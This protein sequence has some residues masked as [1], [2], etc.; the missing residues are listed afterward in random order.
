[1][2]S[3]MKCRSQ[4]ERFCAA[5][6]GLSR[7]DSLPEEYLIYFPDETIGPDFSHWPRFF[8]MC[9]A[10][11]PSP[12]ATLPAARPDLH[13]ISRL[14]FPVRPVIRTPEDLIPGEPLV[15]G[16]RQAVHKRSVFFLRRPGRLFKALRVNHLPV[17]IGF[18]RS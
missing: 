15:P 8:T 4:L 3:Y 11:S 13:R 2:F 6:V 12:S 10:N 14:E 9:A 17:D 7:K 18:I 5:P 1:M 16:G